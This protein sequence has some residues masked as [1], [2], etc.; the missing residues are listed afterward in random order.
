MR[1]LSQCCSIDCPQ[2]G[3]HKQEAL[4]VQ[5]KD[6]CKIWLPEHTAQQE[7]TDL[8]IDTTTGLQLYLTP[9]QAQLQT[10]SPTPP[11]LHKY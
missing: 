3:E 9:T 6:P 10:S 11:S 4:D 8:H 7:A 2:R 1:E 5:R